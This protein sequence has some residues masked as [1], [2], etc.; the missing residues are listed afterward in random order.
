MPNSQE[1][2]DSARSSS[3]DSQERHGEIVM[4]E[5][6]KE[7]SPSEENKNFIIGIMLG[8]KVGET[9]GHKS[10]PIVFQKTDDKTLA[11]IAGWTDIRPGVESEIERVKKTLE[12]TGFKFSDLRHESQ[13][14]D[15]PAEEP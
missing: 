5:S 6:D 4:N 13:P 14:Q 9:W 12:A 7:F 15:P 3:E 10:L 8:L 2:F 1:D 11:C